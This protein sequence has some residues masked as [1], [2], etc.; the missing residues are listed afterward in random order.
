LTRRR[1]G[2]DDVT[3]FRP[4]HTDGYT[5][6]TASAGRNDPIRSRF[7]EFALFLVSPRQRL[8]ERPLRPLMRRVR[9]VL[10]VRDPAKSN[11]SVPADAVTPWLVDT[12]YTF[13]FES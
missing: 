13:G 11:A 9:K 4:V 5:F 3:F 10:R 1:T 6:G 7:A 8:L 12:A 2:R